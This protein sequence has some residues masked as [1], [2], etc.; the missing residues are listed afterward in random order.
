MGK[1]PSTK[2]DLLKQAQRKLKSLSKDELQHF[3]DK[4]C[5]PHRNTRPCGMDTVC[6]DCGDW[7]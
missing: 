3:V 4:N 7:V 2:A 1:K 5:C 6:D